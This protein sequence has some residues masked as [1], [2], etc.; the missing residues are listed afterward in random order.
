MIIIAKLAE[1][2]Q[3]HLFNNRP[4][5][6]VC[7]IKRNSRLTQRKTIFWSLQDPV[8]K[9]KSAALFYFFLDSPVVKSIADIN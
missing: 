1:G 8:I 6:R 3:K 2:Q 4:V 7:L 5:K 9:C